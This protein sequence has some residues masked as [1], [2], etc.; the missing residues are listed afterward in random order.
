MCASEDRSTITG[1]HLVN[2][3]AK[4]RYLYFAA[5][6][7]KP[8]DHYRI[9][10]QRPTRSSM[11]AYKTYRFR[12]RN[13]AAGT[14]LQFLAE[15]QDQP[16]RGRP[17]KVAVSAAQRRQTPCRTWISEIRPRIGIS[18]GRARDPRQ[19]D[20]ERPAS[21]SKVRSGIRRP[22]Y[23]GMYHAFWHPTLYEDVTGEISRAGTRIHQAKGFKN[24]P[25][26][27]LRDTF[28]ATHPL[29]P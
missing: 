26:F 5:R 25:V 22:F 27:P 9:M 10:K 21:K 2:G 17:V 6:Y 29:S 16:Q 8:F 19:M 18:K 15:L 7:S 12:S 28:R 24:S 3:W 23:T 20:R 13:E 11:T 14:N 4:E 1:F